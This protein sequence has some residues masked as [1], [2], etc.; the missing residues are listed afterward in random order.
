[1]EWTAGQPVYQTRRYWLARLPRVSLQPQPDVMPSAFRVG[2]V[3][4][5]GAVVKHPAVVDE[6][7]L[8]RL[9]TEF[10]LQFRLAQRAIEDVQ[11]SLLGGRQGEVGPLVT[12]FDP[13]AQITADQLLP[14][15]VE[16]RKRDRRRIAGSKSP[17]AVEVKRLEKDRQHIGM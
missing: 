7:Q 8:P 16:D 4:E 13:V 6:E 11:R 1:M 2:V 17:P 5:G 12:G 14:L 10:H 3:L 15:P 9:E